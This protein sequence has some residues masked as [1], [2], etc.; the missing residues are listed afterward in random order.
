[1]AARN[2]FDNAVEAQ[3]AQ[4]V[5]HPAERIVSWVKAQQLREQGAHLPIG[6]PSKLKTE[7]YENSQQSLDAGIT[8]AQGGGSLPID[9]DRANDLI[10]GIFADRTIM[11]DLLDV[12]TDVGWLESRSAATRAD[13]SAACRCRSRACR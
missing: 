4:V 6:E 13:S 11:R 5:R 2:S 10:K 8:E 9:F 7:D 1:M 12:Q 3:P